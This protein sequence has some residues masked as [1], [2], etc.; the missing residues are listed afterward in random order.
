MYADTERSLK[1]LAKKLAEGVL[2]LKLF[3]KT[4][5]F[6]SLVPIRKTGAINRQNSFIQPY[7]LTK[8]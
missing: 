4:K 3:L 6:Y 5:S 1:N 2:D 8:V 7:I